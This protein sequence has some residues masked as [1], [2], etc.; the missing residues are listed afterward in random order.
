M[1]VREKL[2]FL[3]Q[4]LSEY[5][6]KNKEIE[7]ITNKT[8]LLLKNYNDIYFL[9]NLNQ[10]IE[11]SFSTAI[12]K[13]ISSHV[14]QE[15][16][17]IN[18]LFKVVTFL[19]DVCTA[20]VNPA[21]YDIYKKYNHLTNQALTRYIL[22]NKNSLGKFLQA[23]LIFDIKYYSD[24]AS[25]RLQHIALKGLINSCNSDLYLEALGK[26][27]ENGLTLPLDIDQLN[28]FDKH[29]WLNDLLQST[30]I[31]NILYS[32]FSQGCV[33]RLMGVYGYPL[34]LGICF[35][36]A[37]LWLRAVLL[38]DS[39][40]FNQRLNGMLTQLKAVH[41][42][43][44]LENLSH[45]EKST[46]GHNFFHFCHD[47]ANRRI[48]HKIETDSKAFFDTLCLIQCPREHRDM[49]N[50]YYTQRS[51]NPTKILEITNSIELEAAGGIELIYNEARINTKEELETYLK[52]LNSVIETNNLNNHFHTGFIITGMYPIHTVGFYYHEGRAILFNANLI[53]TDE[54]IE[55]NLELLA[56]RIQGMLLQ[57][58]NLIAFHCKAYTLGNNPNKETLRNAFDS[59]K[60]TNLNEITPDSILRKTDKGI[61]LMFTATHAYD[62]ACLERLQSQSKDSD[63]I[64]ALNKGCVNIGN[65]TPLMLCVDNTPLFQ[66]LLNKDVNLQ[67]TDSQG[68]NLLHLA[69]MHWNQEVVALL[70]EKTGRTLNQQDNDGK[71][72]L[73]YA[74][75][76]NRIEI[77]KMLLS[78]YDTNPSNGYDRPLEA[79]LRSR[80]HEIT[81]L[82]LQKKNDEMPKDQA[83]RSSFHGRTRSTDIN[84][85]IKRHKTSDVS[86]SSSLHAG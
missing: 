13:L 76:E 42:A 21:A 9:E 2:R 74:I 35:A 3:Y 4:Y 68:R 49:L 38:N 44:S 65:F 66:F 1:M 61:D 79:A 34:G 52:R 80:S 17:L 6:Y 81:N 28:F 82:L 64:A 8:D 57:S 7:E 56:E 26:L 70:L 54:L 25:K 23:L 86:L 27:I 11:I 22:N 20:Y 19:R 12:D 43:A 37:H 51:N 71:T 48:A 10:L 46:I 85:S 47:E 5:S 14:N 29:G 73:I 63:W 53:M 39:K 83:T 50:T 36:L 30:N 67:R 78:H 24:L 40:G 45:Q 16:I 60:E 32:R 55:K 75:E 84:E 58:E 59:F 69:A 15:I 31:E 33:L 41:R 18:S 72:P 62:L 77:V